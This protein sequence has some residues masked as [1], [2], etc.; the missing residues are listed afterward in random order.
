MSKTDRYAT[1]SENKAP[2][3]MACSVAS[4]MGCQGLLRTVLCSAFTSP[5]TKSRNYGKPF[6]YLFY[7]LDI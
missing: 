7:K 6:Y 3:K 2:D 5:L 1:N 4:D